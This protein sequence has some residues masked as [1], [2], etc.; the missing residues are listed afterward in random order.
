[1]RALIAGL[2]L[3][4]A[5]ACAQAQ[6]IAFPGPGLTVA[7]SA[8][9]LVFT[10]N[11]TLTAAGG[12]I[13]TGRSYPGVPISTAA[14]NRTIIV[15]DGFR[16]SPNCPLASMTIGGI[17]ATR[18][19]QQT[20]S[21]ANTTIMSAWVAAVPT[22]TTATIVTTYCTSIDSAEGL[23]V[24]AAY[25]LLSTTPT[26]IAGSNSSTAPGLSLNVNSGGIVIAAAWALGQSG[27]MCS[28]TG[29]TSDYNMITD[30]TSTS[31]IMAG[32][33]VSGASVAT[34]KTVS[35]TYGTTSSGE[36]AALAISLR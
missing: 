2:F 34:P 8:P 23:G 15:M 31:Q 17:S 1:M 28:W 3:C 6:S 36:A 5:L 26:A 20:N 18:V 29:V 25:G 10:N 22:G 19:A 14:A 13:V 9:T 21:A 4:L 35:C 32:A 33:S 30:P 12:G 16:D 7:I 24:Y 11:V 27:T